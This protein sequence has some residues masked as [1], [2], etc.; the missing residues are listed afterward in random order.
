M[1]K[2]AK[3]KNLNSQAAQLNKNKALYLPLQ[4]AKES[5]SKTS[6]SVTRP[7]MKTAI[8]SPLDL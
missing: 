8:K 2:L 1:I 6:S 3:N 7:P 4:N 5:I